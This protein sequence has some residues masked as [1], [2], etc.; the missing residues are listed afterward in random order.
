[1]EELKPFLYEYAYEQIERMLKAN[2]EYTTMTDSELYKI[3]SLLEE[4]FKSYPYEGDLKYSPK[5]SRHEAAV[6]IFEYV[7]AR[8]KAGEKNE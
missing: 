3:A 5:M 1:M 7:Y 2:P 4:E 8:K 6:W